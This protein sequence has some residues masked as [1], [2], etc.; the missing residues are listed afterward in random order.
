M[1]SIGGSRRRSSKQSSTSSSKHKKSPP[2]DLALKSRGSSNS[3]T[4]DTQ[5]T[6]RSIFSSSLRSSKKGQLPKDVVKP[7]TR[8]EALRSHPVTPVEKRGST[9][10]VFAFMEQDDVNWDSPPS[11]T[12]GRIMNHS[13]ASLT[14]DEDGD[15][16]ISPPILG[17]QPIEPPQASPRY[18][19][20]EVKADGGSHRPWERSSTFSD[21]GLHS[22]SGIS[23][24][25]G[26]PDED[27]SPAMQHKYP[28]IQEEEG[29]SPLTAMPTTQTGLSIF[30]EVLEA[31]EPPSAIPLDSPDLPAQRLGGTMHRH[32]PSIET[33]EGLV[34]EACHISSPAPPLLGPR[35]LN[36]GG[37]HEDR[38]RSYI[39]PHLEIPPLDVNAPNPA[40]LQFDPSNHL[41]AIPDPSQP[42]EQ[43]MHSGKKTG[44]ALLASKISAHRPHHPAPQSTDTDTTGDADE[45]GEGNIEED[46]PFLAPI[47]RKFET[48]THRMLLYLQDEISELESQLS[49]LDAAIALETHQVQVQQQ[50]QQQQQQHPN[51]PHNPH[52]N[53]NHNHN[54]N[55][56][57]TSTIS[58]STTSSSVPPA[59]GVQVQQVQEARRLDAK[60]PSRLQWHRADLLGRVGGR[61]EVYQRAMTSYA[62][63]TRDFSRVD[64]GG[65]GGGELEAYRQW[66]ESKAPIAVAETGFLRRE[67]EGDLVTIKPSPPMSSSSTA[68]YA[69][70]GD[71]D[72]SGDGDGGKRRKRKGR[73]VGRRRGG[74]KEGSLSLNTSAAA[75]DVDINDDKDSSDDDDD[76]EFLDTD[77]KLD[78]SPSNRKHQLRKGGSSTKAGSSAA[79]RQRQKT[80][81]L[82]LALLA[83]IVVFKVVP[84][85]FARLVISSMIAVAAASMLGMLTGSGAVWKGWRKRE[86]VVYVGVLVALALL[87]R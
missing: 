74:G 43:V 68:D 32:V 73:G 63:M 44:Y 15:H 41:D 23:M 38:R 72:G 34:P 79:E 85:V 64:I 76:D 22:D 66:M 54:R 17:A 82:P 86:G 65:A 70:N 71:G 40:A 6:P 12:N 57:R 42:S 61:L 1:P 75:D 59:Q 69:V 3:A 47:Y 35:I 36:V 19:D 84:H 51:H 33:S 8:G 29:A 26:S 16:Q 24:H 18:S 10:D 48:L 87:V 21:G 27:G 11:I 9:V 5:A 55:G 25:S 28:M 52:S 62:K 81:I 56:H 2:P 45:A 80:I 67:N 14:G 53:H 58:T 7:V 78:T 49:E 4:S 50:Q 77:T 37:S 31:D 30:E 20:L 39:Q 13:A 83:T 60:L 46:P